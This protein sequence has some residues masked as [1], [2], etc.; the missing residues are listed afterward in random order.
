MFSNL[1]KL[2]WFF[3]ERSK[4]YMIAVVS[5]IFVNVVI[6]IPPWLIGRA[7]DAIHKGTMNYRSLFFYIGTLLLISAADFGFSFLWIYKLFNNAI[8]LQRDVRKR[9]MAK[10]VRMT[11]TFYEKNP[12][13]DLMAK[14]T[15]DLTAIAEM[16]GY[17]VLAFTDATTYM[18]TIV[19][20]MGQFISWKLTLVSLIPLPILAVGSKYIGDLIHKRYLDSQN[21]F[22]AMNDRVLEYIVGVRVVRSYVREQW[23]QEEFF[24]MTQEVYRKNMAVE[25]L[26]GLFV[27]AVKWMSSI[28]YA[29]AIAYGVTLIAAGQIT[30]GNLIS[31]NV[32]LNYIIWPML[33]IGEFINT[34]QRGN[35]SLDRVDETLH[36]PEEMAS[37]EEDICLSQ[38][39][40]VKFQDYDFTYPKSQ[41]ANLQKIDLTIVQGKTV[42]IVGKTGSGK[43]TLIRQILREYPKGQGELFVGDVDISKVNKDSLLRHIG[44][45]PQ[46]H[47]L[48]S[49]SIRDNIL[50]GNESASEE[51]LLAAIRAADFEKDLAQLPQGMETMV[52]ERGIS[53]SG[54]QKQRLSI[55]RALIKKP[56]MLILDDSLSAVDARTEAKIVA[57]IRNAR[58]GK[59]TVITT[60]RLSAVQH[61]DE[62]IVLEEGR[63]KERGNHED[64]MALKGWYRE[65]F[66]IQQLEEVIA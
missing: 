36:Y 6:V 52:G 63:I 25:Y 39:E 45:V 57:N 35:A 18:G 15:N 29:I 27:P 19:F 37:S 12:T 58:F 30:L 47:M 64:L 46:D 41:V 40:S 16:A 2:K 17:G 43:T 31:F 23:T 4:D 13:G 33:A 8:L 20:M 28:S 26:T 62:I 60:H 14:A 3:R 50:F 59:T 7:I 49:R 34:M 5:L 44:Y 61:A 38:I 11:P 53:I 55:A 56:E 22:G 65:Q 32:Y 54:G 21:A 10:L 51:E 42:G 9:L 1:K 24:K 66:D 48:F